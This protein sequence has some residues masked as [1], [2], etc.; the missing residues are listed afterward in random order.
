MKLGIRVKA[1]ERRNC[2]GLILSKPSGKHVLA[3]KPSKRYPRGFTLIELLVVVAVIAILMSILMPALRR[4]RIVARRVVCGTNLRQI[5]FACNLYVDEHD[6]YF[7]QAG[8]SVAF[9]FGGWAGKIGHIPRPLNKYFDLPA[10]LTDANEPKI[11]CC[12]GDRG[13]RPGP[14]LYEKVYTASGNSYMTNPCLIGS[15]SIPETPDTLL[16][17]RQELNKQLDNLHISRVQ[18]PSVLLLVGDYGWY[19]QMNPQ[20]FPDPEWKRLV[21]WHGREDSHNLAYLDCHVKFLKLRKGIV[22]TEEYTIVPFRS[23]YG[24]AFQCQGP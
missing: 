6:G 11:F 12:P 13:G 24:L 3:E 16:P 17:L 19:N 10:D 18:S 7:L 23:L 20:P 14:W 2:G 4:A 5:A 8:G 1:F 21:E 9:Y 22:I 15:G